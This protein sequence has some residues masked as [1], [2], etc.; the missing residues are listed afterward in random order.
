MGICESKP[1]V[2]QKEKKIE[3][4]I[5]YEPNS[6]N[7]SIDFTEVNKDIRI[8]EIIIKNSSFE[9][10]DRNISNISK[11]ICKIKIKTPKGTIYGTGFLLRFYIE[12]EVFYCLISNEHV[13]SKEIIN[14]KNNVD[15]SYDNEIKS[16]NIKLDSN[17]RY[18]KCFIDAGL[19]ITII[20]II[21]E[22]NISKD[23][24]LYPEVKK[25]I[26]NKL[27]NT[28]I[29]IPQYPEGKELKN[30]RGKIKEINKYEFT[31]SASTAYGSS[32][33]PIF[34]ENIKK[35]MKLDRKLL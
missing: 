23:Y 25:K 18:I 26:N 8:K 20:E 17:K 30:A 9:K 6:M 5:K 1:N 19:D 24:F 21:E 12:Q 15:I 7:E 3:T 35:E 34:L 33:S 28:Q 2:P 13:I 31:H 16:V 14:N 29:Y 22:D 4:P 10:I 27:I 11:F 32:G